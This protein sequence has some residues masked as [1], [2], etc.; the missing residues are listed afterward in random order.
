M[1]NGYFKRLPNEKQK[2]LLERN[3]A[4]EYSW[5]DLIKSRGIVSM[6]FLTLWK[7][8]SNHAHAEYIG[9]MQLNSYFTSSTESLPGIYNIVS[10]PLLLVALYI[11]DLISSFTAPRIVYNTIEDDLRTKIELFQ[12]IIKSKNTVKEILEKKDLRSP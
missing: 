5:F 2:K 12:G 11:D 4:R 3:E 10:Q 7:L 9:T 1:D 8:L 6:I